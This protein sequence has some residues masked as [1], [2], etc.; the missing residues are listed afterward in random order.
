MATSEET[1]GTALGDELTH[2]QE[3]RNLAQAADPVDDELV[4]S[5]EAKIRA[6]FLAVPFTF[7]ICYQSRC[8]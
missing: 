1:S 6:I 3:E 5:L 2:L 4:A 7:F 8:E